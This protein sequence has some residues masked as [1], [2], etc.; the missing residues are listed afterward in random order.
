MQL[1]T[2]RMQGP[3][4]QASVTE[5]QQQPS[6]PSKKHQYAFV[7]NKSLEK[8]HA[9]LAAIE[10]VTG[11]RKQWLWNLHN[12]EAE[13]LPLPHPWMLFLFSLGRGPG[14]VGAGKV[15]APR[16][17]PQLAMTCPVSGSRS[18]GR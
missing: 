6:Q 9:M 8:H 10:M 7:V 18:R 17:Q 13:V 2:S 14:S 3:G 16:S 5:Q 12:G 4:A 11:R 15:T 1:C